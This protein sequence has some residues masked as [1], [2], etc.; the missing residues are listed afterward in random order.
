MAV[1]AAQNGGVGGRSQVLITLCMVHRRPLGGIT[2]R[3]GLFRAA[4][5]ADAGG[6]A[7]KRRRLR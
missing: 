6:N 1:I 2:F 7:A 5:C 4:A 3:V